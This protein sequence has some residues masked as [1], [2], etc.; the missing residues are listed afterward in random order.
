M[1]RFLF[2]YLISWLPFLLINGA[3]TGNFTKYPVVNYNAT[4]IIGFRLT[5]IPIEDSMY[6][7]LMLLIVVSVYE[8]NKE[9]KPL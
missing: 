2:A 7:L 3:L 5:T 1:G 6:N 9:M 8:K 4:E